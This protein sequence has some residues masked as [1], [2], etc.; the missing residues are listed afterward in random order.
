MEP[1]IS[2]IR[3]DYDVGKGDPQTFSIIGAAMEVHKEL[4]PGFLE[5]VYQDALALEFDARG[6]PYRRE[7]A[8]YVRYKGEVLPSS[9]RV[10]F[11]CFGDVIVE[12]KAVREIGP[13]D[14]AQILNYLRVSESS[15]GLLLNFAGRSLEHKRFVSNFKSA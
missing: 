9:Y 6:I 15:R 11:V 1:Q 14:R 12:L 5:A 2:Q 13:V 10:D 8:L 4:G 3:A 7:Q